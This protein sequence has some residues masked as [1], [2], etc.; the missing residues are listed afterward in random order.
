MCLCLVFSSSWEETDDF[1]NKS[2]D[3]LIQDLMFIVNTDHKDGVPIPGLELSFRQSWFGDWVKMT[4]DVETSD[5]VLKGLTSVRRLGDVIFQATQ[6]SLTLNVQVIFTDLSA[7][8]D[9][10]FI[11]SSLIKATGSGKVSVDKIVGGFKVTF[12]IDE[13]SCTPVLNHLWISEIS[14][15]KVS[16]NNFQ[17][18]N[19]LLGK[20]TEEIV[21]YIKDDIK[22]QVLENLTKNVLKFMSR[23]N[24]CVYLDLFDYTK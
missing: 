14:E 6:Y 13:D 24:I 19:D 1:I 16:L 15:I 17:I 9:R 12:Y 11:S 18:L 22:K 4:I 8:F 21:N 20:V 7:D 10:I 5:S 3:V 2:V 23:V